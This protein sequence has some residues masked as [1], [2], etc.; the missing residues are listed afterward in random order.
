MGSSSASPVVSLVHSVKLSLSNFK[1]QI[2]KL[3]KIKPDLRYLHDQSAVLVAV[4][5]EGVELRD[6]IVEGLLSQLTGLVRAVE[7]LVIK[8]REVEGQT[9]PDGVGWLK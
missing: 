1:Q 5:V 7:D 4:L 9:E 3:N 6:S 8:H 2:T